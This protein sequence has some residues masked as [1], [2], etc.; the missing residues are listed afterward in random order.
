MKTLF[1][2]L[3]AAGLLVLAAP[4][5]HA[6]ETRFGG[7][8]P[9]EHG[10]HHPGQYRHD[11]RYGYDRNNRHYRTSRHTSRY[12]YRP[13]ADYVYRPFPVRHQYR[14]GYD[15]TYRHHYRY[16]DRYRYRNH[17]RHRGNGLYIGPDG[18]TIFLGFDD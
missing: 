10:R 18:V 3:A 15:R 13:N 9:A 1:L 6:G 17:Y 16:R 5:T 8:A 12:R 14:Y 2:T 4:A 11:R 7:V